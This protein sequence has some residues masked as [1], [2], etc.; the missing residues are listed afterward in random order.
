MN[1]KKGTW[2]NTISKKFKKAAKDVADLL[3]VDKTGFTFL[4]KLIFLK[5]HPKINLILLQYA[6]IHVCMRTNFTTQNFVSPI[7][8][9]IYNKNCV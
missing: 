3:L 8:V 5:E 9:V 1:F 4:V 6:A 7:E 2:P